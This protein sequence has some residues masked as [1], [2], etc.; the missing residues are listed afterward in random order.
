M[1]RNIGSINTVI[2]ENG[3]LVGLGTDGAGALKALADSGV[4]VDGKNVLML[5]AGG[6]SRA[7]SF[8][9]AMNTEPG[10]LFLLDID[11]AQLETLKADLE[12]GTDTRIKSALING[13]TLAAAM[14]PLRKSLRL[15][16]IGIVYPPIG[17]LA[18]ESS[19]ARHPISFCARMY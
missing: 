17:C 6:A 2:H 12:A 16:S 5:G 19:A 13:D 4:A 3:R 1:D 15:A 10:E 7:I 18:G 11:P 9:L 8:T 14:E